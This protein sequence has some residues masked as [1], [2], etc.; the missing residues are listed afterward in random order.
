MFFCMIKVKFVT[1]SQF[2]MQRNLLMA[3]VCNIFATTQKYS[4]IIVTSCN[5]PY[6]FLVLKVCGQGYDFFYTQKRDDFH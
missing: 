3:L 6:D 5:L 2:L 1:S 4:Q